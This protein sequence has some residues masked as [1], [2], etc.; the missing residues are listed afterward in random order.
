[1]K[2]KNI[3]KITLTFI[4]AAI[5]LFIAIVFGLVYLYVK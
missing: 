3:N 2:Q 4:S 5:I 1:M